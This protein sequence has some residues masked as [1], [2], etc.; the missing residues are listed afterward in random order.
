MEKPALVADDFRFDGVVWGDAASAVIAA[1][2]GF[3]ALLALSHAGGKGRRASSRAGGALKP[4][5]GRRSGGAVTAVATRAKRRSS[6]LSRWHG[7]PGRRARAAPE[8]RPSVCVPMSAGA[9][10]RSHGPCTER[11]PQQIG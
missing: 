7:D 11:S 10:A 9:D 5:L 1:A 4:W 2:R 3:R 6:Q 8:V